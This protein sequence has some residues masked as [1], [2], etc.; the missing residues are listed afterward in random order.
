M[1]S[2]QLVFKKLS[3][4][5]KPQIAIELKTRTMLSHPMHHKIHYK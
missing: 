5:Q 4:S 2:Q 3:G 1:L